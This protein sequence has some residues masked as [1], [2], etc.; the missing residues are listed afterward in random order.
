MKHPKRILKLETI[1][2]LATPDLDKVAGGAVA[3]SK[4]PWCHDTFS[5]SCPK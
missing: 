4:Q 3:T 2:I 1:R 5:A